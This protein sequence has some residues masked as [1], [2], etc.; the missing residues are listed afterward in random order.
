[1]IGSTAAIVKKVTQLK[2]KAC[3]VPAGGAAHGLVGELKLAPVETRGLLG[4]EWGFC[5]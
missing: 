2:Q 3:K 1:M 5:L 4:P